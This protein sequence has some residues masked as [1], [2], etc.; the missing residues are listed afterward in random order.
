MSTQLFL[1]LPGQ[2]SPAK[3]WEH[4]PEP[5]REKLIMLFAQLIARSARSKSSARKELDHDPD[6]S[7]DAGQNPNRAPGT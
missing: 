1:P 6:P 5:D 3:I 7:A 2:K 4:F